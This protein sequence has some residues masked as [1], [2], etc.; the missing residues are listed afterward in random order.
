MPV[1]TT[2]AKGWA[3][4]RESNED[5]LLAIGPSFSASGLTAA[6][7]SKCS[8]RFPHVPRPPDPFPRP[9]FTPSHANPPPLPV[10]PEPHVTQ[11]LTPQDALPVPPVWS[12]MVHDQPHQDALTRPLN[13]ADK[14]RQI[15]GS[16][17]VRFVEVGCL[18]PTRHEAAMRAPPSREE[19]GGS[20]VWDAPHS[21]LCNQQRLAK[22]SPL[23]TT[24]EGKHRDSCRRR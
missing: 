3:L 22:L 5:D 21:S 2:N 11:G 15:P 12:Q 9:P 18:P 24:G 6:S 16:C 14:Q 17:T 1:N 10:I 7:S 4:G 19:G 23:M 13:E 8:R 20:F